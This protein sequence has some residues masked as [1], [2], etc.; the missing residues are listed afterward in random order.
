MAGL[1]STS[2]ATPSLSISQQ[3]QVGIGT[4]TENSDV[5]LAQPP[6]ETPRRNTRQRRR[7]QSIL[8]PDPIALP[9]LLKASKPPS[10]LHSIPHRHYKSNQGPFTHKGTAITIEASS[11][12][13]NDS[14]SQP[15]ANSLPKLQV[16]CMARTRVPTPHGEVYLHLYKNNIDDKEHLAFV[17]D[18]DQL[19]QKRRDRDGATS[20]EDGK[21]QLSRESN[22][23]EEND[24]DDLVVGTLRSRSLDSVW[25]EGETD[26]ERIVRGAYVGRL[27]SSCAIPSNE[28][29][30]IGSSS[31]L[32]TAS[33]QTN[34][35]AVL[36]RV[37]SECF[38]GETI[39]SQ[40]CDCGEQ[41][42]EA[43]RLISSS[44]SGLGVIVY[45]RQEGR[46]I[47][48]LEKIKAYN[49]QDLG[50]DTVTANLLLGHNADM[51]T[52]GIAGEILR[53]LR[54][55][56]VRLLTNNPDKIDS[57]ER[58]GI[59]VVE[60]VPMV[61]RGWIVPALGNGKSS[62]R[63]KTHRKPNTQNG[64]RSERRRRE[65]GALSNLHNGPLMTDSAISLLTS[66][67]EWSDGHRE[68][69]SYGFPSTSSRSGSDPDDHAEGGEEENESSYST[70]AS[71][72]SSE[73]RA[74]YMMAMNRTGVGMI[75]GGTTHSVELERYLKT[76]I[77]RMGH[78]LAVPS[79][80]PSTPTALQSRKA[81][82]LNK[83]KSG[84]ASAN[85]HKRVKSRLEESVTS[86]QLEADDSGTVPTKSAAA[87]SEIRPNISKVED[88]SMS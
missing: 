72:S 55:G 45:L 70:D 7:R 36:I 30:V 14:T 71:E 76:K 68:G 67:P 9:A 80:P 44:P 84:N 5:A 58:E 26:M 85:S 48:L 3:N 75:G 49:L 25:R 77:E 74:D 60:R 6:S 28:V 53:D 63:R 73:D 41:L 24:E 79:T 34:D 16:T 37:H 78:M 2:T 1:P 52:Y 35:D 46:G 43:F 59:R 23:E 13:V 17:F 32:D 11:S 56:H 69:S 39:G 87:A 29:E 19:E 82:A 86:L 40:R 8:H 38:T 31:S 10:F 83:I 65:D 42:D 50:H 66:E 27:S 47:G 21:G 4:I 57:V 64:H 22:D 54:V 62:S 51:R 33:S 61:P 18:R 81:K 20:R 88:S 15:S 12:E